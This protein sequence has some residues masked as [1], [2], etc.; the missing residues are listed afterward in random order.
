MYGCSINLLGNYVTKSTKNERYLP[1]TW[2][3]PFNRIIAIK[4]TYL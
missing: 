2:D 3:Q 4:N 1:R